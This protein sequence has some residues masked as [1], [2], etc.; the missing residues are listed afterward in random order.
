MLFGPV[1][2]PE[3]L[4]GQVCLV[5]RR[6]RT[7][8]VYAGRTYRTNAGRLIV[9][10]VRD[11]EAAAITDAD[12]RLAGKADA[13]QARADLRGDPDWPVFRIAFHRAEDP[14]PRAELAARADPQP[15]ELTELHA[16][17]A[18]LDRV[19]TRGPWTRSTLEVIAAQPATRAADLAT[20]LGRE[21]APFKLALPQPGR[22]PASP[23]RSQVRKLK[24][25]G[26]TYSLEVGYRIAPRGAA[27]L[28]WLS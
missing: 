26:L 13:D 8:R 27:Y 16:R 4:T 24:N 15:E 19:S 28:R 11:I 9:E 12:A 6:W 3:I 17:L 20:G 2:R 25:L 5:F 7:A 18:R 21:T 22:V 23:G 1:E 14:D 10:D